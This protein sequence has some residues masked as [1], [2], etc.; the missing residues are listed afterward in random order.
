[1]L[2]GRFERM[3][4]RLA[5]RRLRWRTWFDRIESR[6]YYLIQL[7]EKTMSVAQNMNDKIDGFKASMSKLE[8]AMR[9]MLDL[10][11]KLAAEKA[12]PATDEAVKNAM[13]A[14]DDA[15]AGL[16]ADTAKMAEAA[17]AVSVSGD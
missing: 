4:F 16:D 1:M 7:G 8:D 14:F 13:M 6:I 11:A 9:M 12:D 15:K 10:V 5:I 3:F 2:E 17:A